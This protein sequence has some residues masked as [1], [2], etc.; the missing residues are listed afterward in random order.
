MNKKLLIVTQKVDSADS[1]LGFFHRWIEEFATQYTEV[2]V[3]CLEEGVHTL[4]NNVFVHSLGKKKGTHTSLYDRIFRTFRFYRYVW[5]LKNSYDSVFVHMNPIYVCLAGIV[6]RMQHKRIALWYTHKHVD[7]KLRIAEFFTDVIFT[8]SKESFRLHTPKC[9]VMGHGIDTAVFVPRSMS[10]MSTVRVTTIGRI[11]PIKHC[12]VMIQAIERVLSAGVR[13]ILE[14]VGSPVTPQDQEYEKTLRAYVQK[15]G[16]EQHV[17]FRGSMSHAD[18]ASYLPTQHMC[19]NMSATGSLD[20]AILE[21][22]SCGL[23]VI[24]A[25]EAFAPMLKSYGLMVQS[26]DPVSLADTILRLCRMPDEMVRIGTIL[27]SVVRKEHDLSS[28]I[29]RIATHI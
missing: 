10:D 2:N 3:L 15:K 17:I 27:R 18:I 11:A 7:I 8:A 25:N 20:K 26:T 28:L 23:S 9:I 1:I 29:R 22:M 13:V 4:P 5:M 19:I 21:A 24:T 6:W 16:L 14:I 12:D